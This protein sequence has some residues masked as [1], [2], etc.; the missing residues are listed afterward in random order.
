MVCSLLYRVCFS[1]ELAESVEAKA[2]LAKRHVSELDSRLESTDHGG[3]AFRFA[4]D[5]SFY[6]LKRSSREGAFDCSCPFFSQH[7]TYSH[8]LAL[9]LQQEQAAG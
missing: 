6:E 1:A 3:L 5:H 8:T 4:G 7:W 2:T 9:T